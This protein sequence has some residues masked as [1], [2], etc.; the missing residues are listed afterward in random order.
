MIASW[1]TSV[2]ETN[3]SSAVTLT[4][5]AVPANLV[6]TTTAVIHATTVLADQTH[7]APSL[8]TGR[9]APVPTAWFQVQLR[10]LVVSDHL[11]CLVPRIASALIDL[12][13]SEKCVVP[14]VQMMSD[15]LTTKGARMEL[16]SHS[17]EETMTA[18]M[19]K[20]AKD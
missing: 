17:V 1:D 6:V 13:V 2:Y 12:L 16:V 14:C 7:Y 4:M 10:L 5:I 3:A 19:E 18:A 15:A 20:L 8:I 9:H 11:L